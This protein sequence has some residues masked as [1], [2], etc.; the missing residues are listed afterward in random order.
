MTLPGSL[1]DALAWFGAL[2]NGD[3]QSAALGLLTVA[4]FLLSGLLLLGLVEMAKR[5][6]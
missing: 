4:L 2:D 5:K 3:W 1:P 6:R